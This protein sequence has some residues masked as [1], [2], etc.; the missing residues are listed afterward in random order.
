[1]TPDLHSQKIVITGAAGLVGQN[2][3]VML[4]EMGYQ[5]IVS[6]D[7]QKNNLALLAQ[8]NPGVRTV[9]ADMG[10]WAEELKC[11]AP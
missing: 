5:D 9:L 7:K 3:T 11:A 2:L 6:I 1:M 4:R 10:A 8:L